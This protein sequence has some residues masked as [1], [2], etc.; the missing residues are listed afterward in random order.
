M[1]FPAIVEA[2][3]NPAAG[4]AALVVGIVAAWLGG[5]LLTVAGTCCAVVF[6]L[7]L[8]LK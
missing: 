5:S 2:T 8:I 3:A 1:T 6:L 7:E 4:A